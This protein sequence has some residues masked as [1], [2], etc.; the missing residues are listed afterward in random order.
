MRIGA[1]IQ[2][3]MNSSRFPGKILHPVRHKPMIRYLLGGLEQCRELDDICVSTS[4]E[5]SDDV[6][7]E[8]CREQ[9]IPCIRGPLDDVAGR[10]AKAVKEF[11]LDAFVR[12]CGDSPLLDWRLL[13]LSVMLFREGSWDM[14]SNVMRRT[15]PKG[16]SVEV[17]DTEAFLQAHEN[18]QNPEDLEHVTRY[19]YTNAKSYRIKSIESSGSYGDIQLSVDTPEDM[20]RFEGIVSRMCKPHWEYSWQEIVSFI[21]NDA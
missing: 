1:V 14:V 5:A 6:F 17:V 9:N 19:I 12:V 10:I 16:Q 8:W 18:M 4:V 15:F 7:F 20:A 13:D 2:A 3:R 11:E 21:E